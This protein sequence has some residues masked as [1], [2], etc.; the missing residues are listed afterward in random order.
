MFGDTVYALREDNPGFFT[1]AKFSDRKHP[2]K[3]YRVLIGEGGH[4]TC[5]CPARKANDDKHVIMV[6][7][8][9]KAG[10]PEPAFVTEDG[11]VL[12]NLVWE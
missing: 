2:D 4:G 6:R 8:W 5:S 10:R 7:N 3:V 12:T 11:E 1:V 9:L